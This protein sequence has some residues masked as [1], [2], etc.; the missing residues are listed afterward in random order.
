MPGLTASLRRRQSARSYR[1]RCQRWRLAPAS[2]VSTMTIA[3]ID[4]GDG[5]D[6][7]PSCISHVLVAGGVRRGTGLKTGAAGR[8]GFLTPGVP[9]PVV[10]DPGVAGVAAPGVTA[11]AVGMGAAAVGTTVGAEVE[12]GGAAAVGTAVG[13]GAGARADGGRVPTMA[14]GWIL[15]SWFLFPV[16][17]S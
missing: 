7:P 16:P 6:R 9:P 4:C 14:L 8:R 1:R 3:Q 2:A 11:G 15:R 5:A 17:S 10:P 13:G 12:A